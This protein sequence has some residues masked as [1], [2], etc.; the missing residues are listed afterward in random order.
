MEREAREMQA[1]AEHT[2][3]LAIWRSLAKVNRERGGGERGREKGEHPL[4][5]AD[6]LALSWSPE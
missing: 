3:Y 4:E 6:L 1:N 2:A 5:L